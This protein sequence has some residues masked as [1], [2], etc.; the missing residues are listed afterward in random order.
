MNLTN[1]YNWE[2]V[3]AHELNQARILL[4]HVCYPPPMSVS[5]DGCRINGSG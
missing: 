4:V 5:V 1:S 3:A 2:T